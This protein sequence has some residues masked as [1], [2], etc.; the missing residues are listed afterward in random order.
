MK[1]AGRGTGRNPS[2]LGTERKNG[3]AVTTPGGDKLGAIVGDIVGSA[4]EFCPLEGKWDSFPLFSNKSR[5]TDDTVM[6]VAVA[7]ALR[8][9][10]GKDGLHDT[11]IDAMHA[12]GNALPTAGYGQKL[13]RWLRE[14]RRDPYN[15]FGNGSATRVSP[16]GWVARSLDEAEHLAALSAGVGH[17]HPEGIK[18]AQAVAGAVFLARTGTSRDYI[19]QYITSKYT[20]DISRSIA[21]IRETYKF[22]ASCQGAVPQAITTFLESS[23]FEEAVR[24]AVWLR[25]DADTQAAIAGSIAEAFYGEVPGPITKTALERL[26]DEL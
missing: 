4:F 25:G 11:F 21:E 5:F 17:N 14:H 16:V 8:R 1:V 23:S 20:Y 26:D 15:S 18:G 7:D 12:F 9:G 6:T 22:D 13:A 3:K 10:Y 24:K 2:I 19:R